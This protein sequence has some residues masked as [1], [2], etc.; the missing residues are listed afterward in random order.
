MSELFDSLVQR[1]GADAVKQL[2]EPQDDKL[3]L[4]T[5]QLPLRNDITVLLTD[6]L[7]SYLMPVLPKHKGQEHIELYF[8]LPA[9]WDLSD[10]ENPRMNWV[11]NWLYR[12]SKHV[13]EKQTWFGLGH[14]I[15][16]GNPIVPLSETMKQSYF[17][18]NRPIL[19]KEHLY[20]I[21]LADKTVNFLALTP[22][23]EDEFDY[24]IGKGTE[25]MQKKL[26]HH[27]VDEL[28]DDYRST[29]LKSKW[30]FSGK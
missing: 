25:K 8:C 22:I 30:R 5:I 27:G 10:A 21:E 3:G 29:V 23:F 26:A 9:Y 14:T 12:L 17:F 13:V 4:I 6:G 18:M 24:K 2:S 7:S 11:I 20:P 16:T 15:P 28:L 19:L 1:F